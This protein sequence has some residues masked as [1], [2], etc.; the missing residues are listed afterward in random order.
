MG[1]KH[2]TERS[3]LTADQRGVIYVEQLAMVGLALVL[4]AILGLA[5]VSLFAPRYQAI[6]TS[7]YAGVP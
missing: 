2:G 3:R 1:T 4:A 5:G 7:I 6:V